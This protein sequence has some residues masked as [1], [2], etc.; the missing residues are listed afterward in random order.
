MATVSP[1][2]LQTKQA[3][4]STYLSVF[5]PVTLLTAL[6]NDAGATRGMRSIPYDTGSGSGFATIAA[7]Q[8]LEVDTANGTK[9]TLV[10]SITGSQSTGTIQ[11]YEN[12]IV[13]GNNQSI[14]IKHFYEPHPIPPAIRSGVFYKFFDAAYSAQNLTPNPIA[15]AGSHRAGFLTAGSIAFALSASASYAIASGA[16]I[17][18]YLWSC[19][20]NG[21]A[22]TGISFS[23]TTSATPTLTITEAGQYWLKLIVTDSNGKTQET[24]RALFVYSRGVTDPYKDFTIQSFTGD[25]QSGGWKVS[26]QATGDVELSDFPDGSLC[27]LWHEN[28]F[29]DVAGYVNLWAISNEILTCGYLRQDNSQDNF[30]TG[31]GQATFQISTIDDL[32]NNVA[33]LGS[34]SLNAT[35]SPTKWYEYASWMTAGRSIHHLLLWHAWG[36]FQCVDVL[37]L[38]SNTLG[39][40]TTDYSESS[41]LQQVNGFA[42]DRGIFAKL[43]CD[44]L[45][46]MHLVA[47]SQML[48][49]AARA[50][51]DT[52]FTITEADI[53]GGV[54]LARSPEEQT[55]FTQLD[56]FS[57][58]GSTSTPFISIIPGYREN[59][60]SYIMPEERGGSTAAVSNQVL[61]DQTDSNMKVGRFHALQNNNPRELRFSNPYNGLGAFDIIPSIGWYA[62]GIA[63][64][65]LKRNTELFGRNLVCRNVN[66][67]FNHQ[68]GTIFT[69]VVLEREAIGPP[70]IQGNYPTGYPAA[71]QPTPDWTPPS[72]NFPLTYGYFA[73]GYNGSAVVAT[74]DRITLATGVTAANAGSN[75]SAARTRSIGL[76]DTIIYGYFVGGTDAASTTHVAT[77]DRITLSTSVTAANAGSNLSAARTD[78]SPVSDGVTYGYFGGGEGPTPTFTT[79]TTVDRITFSTSITAAYGNLFSAR[80]SW[81]GFSNGVDKGYCMGDQD[82]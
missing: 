13:W 71:A 76:S 10:K 34:V 32:L 7:G 30:D 6:V 44:R 16:T 75:L 61:A 45:G 78:V 1:T 17:S 26:L 52:V 40:K 57:F 70:G 50:A 33:E 5:Q 23:S 42:H 22:A 59:S 24:Y 68:A 21:G 55:T 67:R 14:R 25:W 53:S 62:W 64:A 65:D 49:D 56:G 28:T 58:N 38:T 66:V 47:D 3:R 46:R 48:S 74:T 35:A 31:T 69:D 4:A 77:T 51:L 27:V 79:L 82:R 72:L 29:N 81:A 18:S 37:G 36:I 60:I 9:K 19:I 11:L 43:I 39:V 41:L 80:K 15:I 20:H 54:D 8:T 2:D 12:S 63:D 73:G